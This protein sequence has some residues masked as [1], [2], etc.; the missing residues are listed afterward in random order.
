MKIIFVNR[1]FYPNHSATSQLVSDLA[2][3]LACGGY[4]VHV[5]TGRQLYTDPRVAPRMIDHIGGT[6]RHQVNLIARADYDSRAI[7]CL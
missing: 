3:D 4:E 6:K 2:F 7:K 5:I 1:Y